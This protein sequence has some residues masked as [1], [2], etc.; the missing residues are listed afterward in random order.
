MQ[1]GQS[2]QP[3]MI[4]SIQEDAIWL[5]NTPQLGA[6]NQLSRCR[7]ADLKTP[8]W[9]IDKDVAFMWLQQ[10]IEVW[11]RKNVHTQ[12]RDIK[13]PA[14]QPNGWLNSDFWVVRIPEPFEEWRMHV[15]YDRVIARGHK[16]QTSPPTLPIPIRNR[17]N[18]WTMEHTT[19]PP[20]GLRAAAKAAVKACEYDFGA[21]DMIVKPNGE[22]VVL[23]VNRAPGL[24]NYTANAYIRAFKAIG[25]GEWQHA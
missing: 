6:T 23:E 22:V 14:R 4:A 16:I 24:D 5:N 3:P 1:S 13:H 18:G 11:G 17:R 8:D 21:V 25:D 15:C 20:K 12:G 19:E 2:M 7:I 10:S 9:T